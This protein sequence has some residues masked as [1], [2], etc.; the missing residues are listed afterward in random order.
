MTPGRFTRATLFANHSS[1]SDE[2]YRLV[3]SWLEK[4]AKSVKVEKYSTGGWE[5]VWDV[6]A[7]EEALVDIPERFKCASDW[8]G[9]V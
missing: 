7:T 9:S 3:C 2:D 5:H 6:E 1:D 4:W 8:A